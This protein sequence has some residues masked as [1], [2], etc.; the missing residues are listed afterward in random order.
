MEFASSYPTVEP[1]GCVLGRLAK[2]TCH[3]CAD[4]CPR[5]AWVLDDDGLG[6]DTEACDGCGLC[7]AVCPE[8]AIAFDFRPVERPSRNG[9][10]AFAAC[11]RA[12]T[13][14]EGG[15]VPCLHGLGTNE[16]ARL[17]TRGVRRLAV[18][19]G[20][21]TAC[22]LNV[23][24]GL[25]SHLGAL[26]RLTDDRRLEPLELV[27]MDASVWREWREEARNLSRRGLLD[28]LMRPVRAAAN[29]GA[30]SQPLNAPGADARLPNRPLARVARF[31]PVIDA[32]LCE[33]CDA[34]VEVCPHGAL[35]LIVEAQGSARYEV[36]A[37]AC[38]SCGLCIDVCTAGAMGIAQWGAARP[39]AVQLGS[40]QCRACG[41][42]FH[43]PTARSQ[44]NALCRICSSTGHHRKLF[45]VLD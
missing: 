18:A 43:F 31:T 30:A 23:G 33:G 15:A 2:A 10:I 24:E 38:S 32:L 13:R 42:V 1:D 16:L 27:R 28:T 34:C 45:Q 21:C 9:R 40:N 4:V 26:R 8:N 36:D 41:N 6:L 35:S 12:V 7:A 44:H 25:Q 5:D 3:A 39:E 17:W 37:T 19:H 29:A 20:D 14:D 22:P 11:E